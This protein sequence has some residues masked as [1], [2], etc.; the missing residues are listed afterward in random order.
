MS[1]TIDKFLGDSAHV[2]TTWG[3]AIAALDAIGMIHHGSLGEIIIGAQ[4]GVAM[5]DSA[6]QPKFDFKDKAEAKNYTM[7]QREYG[8]AAFPETGGKIGLLMIMVRDPL[9]EMTYFYRI[10]PGDYPNGVTITHGVTKTKRTCIGILF[11]GDRK[12]SP[13]CKWTKYLVGNFEEMCAA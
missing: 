4:R 2:N 9:S 5:C 8:W 10:P 11:D 13:R 12:P 1:F 6:V 7:Y 3:D